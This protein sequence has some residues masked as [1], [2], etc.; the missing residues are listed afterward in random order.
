MQRRW[1]DHRLVTVTLDDRRQVDGWLEAWRE[2]PDGWRGWV[3]YSTVPPR[4]ESELWTDEPALR[5]FCDRKRRWT[6]KT[7]GA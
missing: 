2:D 7:M 6:L 3:R 5:A 4:R 1:E